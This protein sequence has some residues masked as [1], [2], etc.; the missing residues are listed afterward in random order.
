MAHY[1]VSPT[2]LDRTFIPT[3]SISELRGLCSQF[4]VSTE[5]VV[6][7]ELADRALLIFNAPTPPAARALHVNSG[8]T[9]KDT[10]GGNRAKQEYGLTDADLSKFHT[11]FFC[12]SCDFTFKVC[13]KLKMHTRNTHG[14]KYKGK[15]TGWVTEP[16]LDQPSKTE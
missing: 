6:E 11:C 13:E 5:K 12:K 3:L 1:P 4:S 9:I 14:D 7:N 15:D 16:L 2:D 10:I 8:N